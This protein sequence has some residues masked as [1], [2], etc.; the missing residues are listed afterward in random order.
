M[1]S[2]RTAQLGLYAILIDGDYSTL[3]FN[4]SL[5]VFRYRID[6]VPLD[7]FERKYIGVLEGNAKMEKGYVVLLKTYKTLRM[8]EEGWNDP[9]VIREYLRTM[10]E[11]CQSFRTCLRLTIGDTFSLGEFFGCLAGSSKVIKFKGGA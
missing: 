6:I 1:N 8:D 2:G 7:E 4:K 11:F 10:Y 5:L 3:K 9:G